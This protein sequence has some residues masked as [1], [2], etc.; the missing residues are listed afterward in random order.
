MTPNSSAAPVWQR[1]DLLASQ[2]DQNLAALRTRD[3]AL[4]SRLAALKPSADYFVTASDRR[5][6]LARQL[7]GQPLEVISNRVLPEGA[8]Q[9]AMKLFPT[10]KCTEPVLVAGLDQGWLWN[11]LYELEIHTPHAPGHTPPLYFLT[12][13]L[14]RLRVVMH[15]HDWRQLLA[16]SRTRLFAGDDAVAQAQQHMTE[17]LHVPMPKLCVTVDQ[18]TWPTGTNID[19][20]TGFALNIA[21]QRIKQ[22][23][24]KIDAAYANF[25]AGRQLNSGE[26]LRVMG[27]TSR[28]TTF[29]QYSM[30]DWLQAFEALGHETQLLIE[31]EPAAQFNPL[32]FADAVARFRPD[33]IVMIDHYRGEFNGLPANIPWVMWVQ[34]QLPNMF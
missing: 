24:T 7:D 25:G 5:L 10:G 29:L 18:A 28:F 32:V 12:A 11:A 2:F 31:P 6:E 19:T 3:A 21:N 9:I 30:R 22:L 1:L 15:L 13:D 16:D 17:N 4:A 20:V 34:D 8:A 23:K 26:P 33:L 14:E 27:I